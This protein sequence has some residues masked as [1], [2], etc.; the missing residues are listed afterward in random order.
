M[1]AQQCSHSQAVLGALGRRAWNWRSGETEQFEP[2]MSQNQDWGIF[3]G[4]EI[5]N[6]VVWEQEST[7][8]SLWGAARDNDTSLAVL[9]PGECKEKLCWAPVV[10]PAP[11][12]PVQALYGHFQSQF[13]RARGEIWSH[14]RGSVLVPRG[15]CLCAQPTPSSP[16]HYCLRALRKSILKKKSSL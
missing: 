15:R 12:S 3:L 8:G 5:P 13:T 14:P 11:S 4:P 6:A 2:E 7:L 9:T 1:L 10:A 16:L